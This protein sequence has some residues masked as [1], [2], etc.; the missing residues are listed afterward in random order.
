MFAE[1][2]SGI[3]SIGGKLADTPRFQGNPAPTSIFNR[4]KYTIAAYLRISDHDDAKDESNSITSQRAIIKNYISL[5]SEFAGADVIDYVDDGI[6]GSHT[7]R[8]AYQQLMADI[9]RG[10]VQC[11]VVKDLSRIGRD[12]IDVDDLLMNFLV[13]QDVRFIAINNNY[14]SLKNPLSNLEL[15][16][17]NLANQ[18]YNKD[19]AQKSMSS[20]MIKMKKGEFLSCWALFGYKKSTT[21]RNKIVIDEE[22]AEYVRLIF[23]LAMDGN[24]P[25]KIAQILNAQGIPT[26]SEYKK[27]HGIIGGWK[28]ADPDFT[29]WCNALV[30]RIIN[31]IRYTGVSVHNMNRV[32][33][34]GK[35]ACLRR[36]KEE[37]I[38]VPDSHDA[39]VTSTEFEA[40]HK[41]IRKEKLSDVPI[42][43]I[44]H[45][46][47]KCPVC[48]RT[49]KRT[50]PLN[51]WFKC[52]SKYYTDHYDCPDCT[53]FQA[54][55]EDIVLESIKVYANVMV[56][57]EEM[58]LAAIQQ[59]GISKAEI[60]GKIKLESKAIKTL[61][62]SITANITAL[63]S[64]KITQDVFLSKKETINTT[65]TKKNADLAR[66]QEQL[67]ALIEGKEAI[68]QR[69][70]ELR[71]LL[72]VQKLDR[73]LVDLLIDKVL[74][75]GEKDIEIVWLNKWQMPE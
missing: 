43:H 21:E 31:D 37:W 61:E 72:T 58:K 12:M 9:G 29:Y 16:I 41:A 26:P 57:Q 64:G 44:F 48:N 14:D 30:G 33:Q 2:V 6:S 3:K 39:I 13:V 32:K 34:S 52:K 62:N 10:A 25:S 71:P 67:Q 53:I 65:L 66:L 55:I 20:K 63:V 15:A 59:E 68:N 40:A 46:K 4:T 54:V 45:G 19:L 1:N 74:I 8:G 28:T 36:P 56:D 17:I 73:E 70:T 49:L 27:K 47:V 69:L 22:S 42:D 18:H 24:F 23:S 75:H 35:R 38:I 5:Q 50:N 7:E 60:E 51:P 11:I